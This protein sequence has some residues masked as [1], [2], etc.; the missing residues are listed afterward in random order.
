MMVSKTRWQ[1]LIAT[2]LAMI[3]VSIKCYFTHIQDHTRTQW[4][5]LPAVHNTSR[6]VQIDKCGYCIFV[7]TTYLFLFATITQRS[8]MRRTTKMV[9]KMISQSV[10]GLEQIT[11]YF[12]PSNKEKAM[13]LCKSEC[14]LQKSFLVCVL[15]NQNIY[16]HAF[17]CSHSMSGHLMVCQHIIKKIFAIF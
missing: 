15:N 14:K 5:E 11:C 9:I 12:K 13:Q 4:P 8:R 10:R 6:R 2:V 17:P 3:A 16:F 1:D 7:L